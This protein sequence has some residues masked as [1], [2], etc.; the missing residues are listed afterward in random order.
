MRGVENLATDALEAL[1]YKATQSLKKMAI[2]EADE[3]RRKL[4][5]GEITSEQAKEMRELSKLILKKKQADVEQWK[6]KESI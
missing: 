6:I 1:K 4:K 3:I 5:A 2:Q